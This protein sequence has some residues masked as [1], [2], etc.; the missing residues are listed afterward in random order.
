MIIDGGSNDN[1]VEIIKKYEKHLAYWISEKDSGQSEAINKGF[2]KATGEIYAFLNS[3]DLL[4]T[5]TLNRVAYLFT[6]HNNIDLIYANAKIINTNDEYI[7]L[8]VA[9]PFRMKDHLADVFAIPQPSAFW[10]REVFEKVGGLNIEN[11]TCMD[12]EFFAKAYKLGF[13]FKMYDEI[14]S[15]FRIH[16]NSKTGAKTE[17]FLKDYYQNQNNYFLNI[18]SKYKNNLNNKILN[19]FLR[20]KFTP[21]KIIKIIKYHLNFYS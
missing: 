8:S 12:G 13:R 1:S 7:R 17:A 20:I 4:E 15:S 21:I 18:D 6:H 5:N 9:L 10:R 2:T 16:S 3:D 19:I 14:W 11:H